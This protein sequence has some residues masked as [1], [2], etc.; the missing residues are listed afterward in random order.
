MTRLNDLVGWFIVAILVLS[1]IP[2]GSNPPIFWGVSGILVG[3]V[4]MI[5]FA[6]VLAAGQPMR[7]SLRHIPLVTTLFA[8]LC[9]YL[10][11]QMLPVDPQDLARARAADA[12]RP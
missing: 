8:L 3:L 2:L 9:A 5:Y 6:R 1:P 4:S 7:F 11:V 10:V 12:G